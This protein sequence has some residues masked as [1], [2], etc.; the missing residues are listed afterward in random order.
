MTVSSKI[1][2]PSL[3][4][5]VLDAPQRSRKRR[6]V[7]IATGVRSPS[8]AEREYDGNECARSPPQHRQERSEPPPAIRAPRRAARGA[9][10]V[11][12]PAEY[13]HSPS[14]RQ[15]AQALHRYSPSGEYGGNEYGG[16]PANLHI[17]DPHRSLSAMGAHYCPGSAIGPPRNLE[18]L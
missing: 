9:L 16:L 4:N 5:V 10:D 1:R 12:E 8:H 13:S 15:D 11:P 2:T 7:I 17:A 3:L 18:T 14:R 6:H